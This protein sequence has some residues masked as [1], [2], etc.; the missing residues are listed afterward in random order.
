M[1]ADSIKFDR[2]AEFYDATRG[3]PPGVG[4]HAAA[5]VSRAGH[6]TPESR[7]L[8]IGVGTGRIALPVSH[9]AGA[10]F[11]ID[12]SAPMLDRLREKQDGQPV[13]VAQADATRLPFPDDSFDAAV[14]VH[15][16]HLIPGWQ[17]ALTE[18]K[19]VLRP[20]GMLL[21]C[22]GGR[23]V[24]FAPLMAAWNAVIPD[25]ERSTVGA[26]YDT[27]P[28]FLEDEGWTPVGDAQEYT[29]A[30]PRAPQ[31]FV[32][33]LAGRI[34]SRTWR[35]SDETLQ[36]GIAAVQA[37]LLEHYADPSAPVAVETSFTVQAYMPPSG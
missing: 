22:W 10:Y 30:H 16:F 21:H 9:Y 23:N 17:T 34:W 28:Q 26:D 4:P 6:L 11:G 31:E 19:R 37:A 14:A 20:G 27:Q 33:N 3:F 2:A 13:Y 7:V 12:L 8:E 35:L 18:L 1:T 24:T 36:T 32:D 5:L 15:V 29:F 25:E